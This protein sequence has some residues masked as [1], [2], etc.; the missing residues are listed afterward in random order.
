MDIDPNAPWTTICPKGFNNN[1]PGGPNMLV[2]NGSIPL[3][4]MLNPTTATPAGTY[5]YEY[6]ADLNGQRVSAKIAVTVNAIPAFGNINIAI[7]GTPVS[8]QCFV[9]NVPVMAPVTMT[10][11]LVGDKTLSCTA[12]PGYIV[13]SVNPQPTQTLTA[14][15]TISYAVIY[16][17]AAPQPSLYF[18][19]VDTAPR[20]GIPISVTL[21]GSD[22]ASG[23][24][25]YVCNSSTEVASCVLT[26]TTYQGS[27]QV[28]LPSV[29]R[30]SVGTIY[31]RVK[32]PSGVWS[33]ST[34][35]M[36]V[37]N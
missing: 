17:Y 36:V 26:Q 9:N 33:P 22:M 32:N 28:W 8:V 1:F 4:I 14:G 34:L 25:A 29:I 13:Y 3:S 19:T 30:F 10:N 11:Q 7:L 2:P 23:V 5:H 35:T 21:H 18:L 27:T 31:L 24:Q 37:I 12:P 16:T 6:R 15:S 20:V